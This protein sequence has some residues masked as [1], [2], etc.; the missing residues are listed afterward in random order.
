MCTE[1]ISDKDT[2]YRLKSVI[3]QS[4]FLQAFCLGHLFP[5]SSTVHGKTHG[6]LST[7]SN[8]LGPNGQLDDLSPHI[9]RMGWWDAEELPRP[10]SLRQR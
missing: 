4:T 10:K 1:T 2:W 8:D 3:F 9:Q 7:R 6:Y 5:V